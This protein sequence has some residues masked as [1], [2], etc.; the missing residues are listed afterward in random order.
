MCESPS[1]ERR[2]LAWRLCVSFSV[3]FKVDVN[4]KLT[5]N[6][7]QFGQSKLVIKKRA[8]AF[9]SLKEE[10][11]FLKWIIIHVFTFFYSLSC[12][13]FGRFQHA[14]GVK[15]RHLF[16][17]NSLRYFRVEIITKNYFFKWR[18]ARYA[19]FFFQSMRP[20]HRLWCH[21]LCWKRT[22]VQLNFT[23]R[24]LSKNSP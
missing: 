3:D 23:L 16:E 18:D 10:E 22:D 2:F 21:F 8:R 1:S 15:S 24:V 5:V 11:K 20:L 13:V 4:R 14:L 7:F 6:V 17:F 19:G 12:A 9:I